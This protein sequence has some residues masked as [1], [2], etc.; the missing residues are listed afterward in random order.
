MLQFTALTHKGRNIVTVLAR[1]SQ[2]AASLV[3]K[4]INQNP[5][6]RAYLGTWKKGGM[7]IKAADG[8]V[9]RIRDEKAAQHQKINGVE[10]VVHA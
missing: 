10:E 5:S 9:T 4:Q 1:S 3:K 2:E 8:T 7:A 6:R